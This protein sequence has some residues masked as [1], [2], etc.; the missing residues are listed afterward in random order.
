[1][2]ELIVIGYDDHA[3]AE[4]AFRAVQRLE[5]DKVVDL[6]G[7]AVLRVD[8]KGGTH[9]DT[10]RREE[11]VAMPATAGV[12]CGPSSSASFSPPRASAWSAPRSGARS[13]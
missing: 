5:K 1:M 12:P 10:P 9:V 6:T 13:D 8:E 2:S 7:L 11:T 4:K 3:A